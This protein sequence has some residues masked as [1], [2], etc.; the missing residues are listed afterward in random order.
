[1]DPELLALATTAGTAV[2]QAVGTDAWHGLR[3]GIARL[4]RRGHAPEAAQQTALER[5]DRTAAEVARTAPDA[6]EQAQGLAAASW[7]TRFRDLLEDLRDDE[8]RA[9]V[10]AELRRL[11]DAATA[12]A[13]GGVGL[14]S[15]NTFRGPV[16]FQV[17]NNN[18]QDVRFG[19]E[20]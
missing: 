16:A 5:L 9:T 10:A 15:G 14:V 8:E 19:P 4:F 3:D 18:R 12:G 7:Q 20:S 6:V 11:L 17:G 13:S 1:M 2:A